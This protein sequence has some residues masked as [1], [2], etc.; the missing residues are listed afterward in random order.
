MKPPCGSKCRYKCSEKICE[1]ERQRIF[2]YYWA[3]G[4]IVLQRQFISNCTKTVNPKYRFVR[5][6]AK[7]VSRS[8]NNSFNFMCGQNLV[9]VCKLFFKNTLDINDRPIRTVLEQQNKSPG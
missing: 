1:E 7:P 9:R 8:H 5:L 3:L 4:D 6:G 2:D